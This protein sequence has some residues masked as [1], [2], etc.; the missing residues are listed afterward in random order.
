MSKDPMD[1][2]PKRIAILKKLQDDL[3]IATDRVAN[4]EEARLQAEL[5][6]KTQIEDVCILGGVSAESYGIDPRKFKYVPKTAIVTTT[7]E[8]KS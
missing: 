4:A 1:V 8:V 7:G 5:N 3:A 6:L 2:D